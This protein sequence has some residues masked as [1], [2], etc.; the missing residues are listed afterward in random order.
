M[1]LL[2]KVNQIFKLGKLAENYAKENVSVSFGLGHHLVAAIQNF[3][4]LKTGKVNP[5][6]TR[7]GSPAPRDAPLSQ[8]SM[9][10]SVSSFVISI[11]KS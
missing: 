6:F 7:M 9:H 11:Q 3:A 2:V 10:S 4:T 8:V 5:S 1:T